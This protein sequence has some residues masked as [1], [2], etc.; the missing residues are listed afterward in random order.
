MKLI[1]SGAEIRFNEKVTDFIVLNN[2]IKGV[3]TAS[4]REYMSHP[5]VLATG[6]SARDI[7]ELLYKKKVSLEKK[8]FAAGTRIEHPADEINS[9]QYGNSR[10]RDILPAAGYSLAYNNPKS[11]RGIY[12]FCMCPGG[13]VINSSSETEM[14]CTNGMSLSQR[15]G[16]YSN[17]AIVVTVRP[18]DTGPSPLS[19]IYFQREIEQ[20]AFFSGGGLF[21]A[22]SQTIRAFMEG[23]LD[24]SIP[25]TSYCNGTST[26]MLK[27]FLPQFI[28]DEILQSLHAFNSKMKGFISDNAVFIGAE[29]RTSSPV[30]I[31]RDK[32]FQSISHPGLFPIGE[33]AGYAGGIV[34]SA[35]DGIRCADA[36]INKNTE[37]FQ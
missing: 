10:Y 3:I 32:N 13:S 23:R 26:S 22:P 9:I 11:G 37:L 7:Y 24:H 17:S 6:H 12:S 14:L 36:L 31:L 5:I 29:T 30:R 21:K 16:L 28:C 27:S 25:D 8:G 34:S 1:N 4:G 15:D 35:V 20:K 18:E 33:G 19:G 2:H